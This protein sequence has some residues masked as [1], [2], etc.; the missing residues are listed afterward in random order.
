MFRKWFINLFIFIVLT[1]LLYFYLHHSHRRI[2]YLNYRIIKSISINDF[3][4]DNRKLTFVFEQGYW[5]FTLN[6]FLQIKF[7]ADISSDIDVSWH[8][9]LWD[10]AM[11]KYI[12]I[13]KRKEIKFLYSYRVV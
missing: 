12:Y 11:I 3:K 7:E 9:M 2:S 1:L 4:I 13:S 8:F 6:S 5:N 10:G